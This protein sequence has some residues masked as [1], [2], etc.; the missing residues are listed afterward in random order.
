MKN[1]LFLLLLPI[2]LLAQ[3]TTL[4][5]FK[6]YPFPTEL[7]AAATGAKIAWAL[8]EKGKRNVYVAEDR[9]SVV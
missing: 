6:S 7:C 3:N 5:S 4:Q 1:F 8:D 9:K 2:Q